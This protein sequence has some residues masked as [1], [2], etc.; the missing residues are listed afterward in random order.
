VWVAD[1]DLEDPDGEW[2]VWKAMVVGVVQKPRRLTWTLDF[3]M[4]ANPE[5]ESFEYDDSR[6]FT[7]E[8]ACR[9]DLTAC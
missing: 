6:V 7:T 9:A 4:G 8:A 1:T 2:V 3:S 5:D